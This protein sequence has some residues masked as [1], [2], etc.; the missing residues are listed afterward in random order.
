MPIGNFSQGNTVNRKLR[1][2]IIK[3]VPILPITTYLAATVLPAGAADLNVTSGT[4]IVTAPGDVPEDRVVVD[5]SADDDATLQ[6][7]S[8]VTFSKDIIVNNGGLL[9]NEGLILRSGASN[10]GV[11]GDTGSGRVT[12]QAGGTITSDETG[13]LLTA[14]GT[15]LNTG[16]GTGINGDVGVEIQGAGSS[17]V[18][19]DGATIHGATTGADIFGD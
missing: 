9:I 12:N 17:L 14:E 19:A 5:N 10:H 8:G 7:N 13:I 4:F 3:T 18:N 16:A 15:V 2:Y 1:R 6:I 11:T